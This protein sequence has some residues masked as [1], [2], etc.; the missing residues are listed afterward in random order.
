M[1]E[2]IVL[3]TRKQTLH[4]HLQSLV[5]VLASAFEARYMTV[6]GIVD[7]YD[8]EVEVWGADKLDVDENK[9]GLK[10]SPTK[11]WQSFPKQ[12][13][14]PGEVFEVSEEEAVEIIV[15]KLKEKHLI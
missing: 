1:L 10:G 11:V 9:L 5:T 12:L 4:L 7:A 8:K 14:A 3:L 6:A 15:K 2:M 13:K